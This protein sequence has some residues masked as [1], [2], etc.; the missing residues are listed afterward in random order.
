MA[1]R[2]SGDAEIRLKFDE[3]RRIY[4]GTVVDPHIRFRGWVPITRTFNRNPT[5]PDAYDDAAQRLAA[6]AQ[7]CARA[8][9]CGFRSQRPFTI[10]ES[11]QRVKLR[12]VF[13]SPCPLDD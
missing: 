8:A 7:R 12:R 4:R 10:E 13:Q 2:Y 3:H 11:G 5:S 9:E 6:M 1:I